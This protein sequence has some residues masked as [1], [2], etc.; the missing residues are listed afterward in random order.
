MNLS[1][2]T[3][4]YND[5]NGLKKTIESVL[6]QTYNEF[7]YIVIDGG[8]ND[9]SSEY[10]EGLS[11]QVDYWVSEKDSG[12]YNAM[13]KGIKKAQ[14]EYLMF[15]N[16]GDWL[17]S[18]ET[19]QGI[20]QDKKEADVLFGNVIIDKNGNTERKINGP[21]HGPVT[22]TYLLYSTIFHQGSFIR[23]SVFDKFGN[24]D[25]NYKIISDWVLF[26][27]L[28]MNEHSFQY[29]DVD[30]SYFD[31][32]GISSQDPKKNHEERLKELQKP[33][34]VEVLSDY[35][36]IQNMKSSVATRKEY[37]IVKNVKVL[38]LFIRLYLRWYY[39]KAKKK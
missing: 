26:L 11:G 37:E 16:S 33:E 31:G 2:I 21:S 4:N 32:L 24:Y 36:V 39:R 34:Y 38:N 3:I 6:G 30:V 5:L 27:K 15:L 17:C 9:G 23:Q 8:S 1:I 35:E 18:K 12:I 22:S 20:F 10:L 13:N 7:E 29:I 25:E 28:S 14:G 19:L